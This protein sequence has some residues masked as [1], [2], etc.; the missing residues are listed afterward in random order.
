[1]CCRAFIKAEYFTHDKVG[2]TVFNGKKKKIGPRQQKK[3]KD[4]CM[5]V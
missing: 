4:L 5:A 1:M 3:K 2:Q